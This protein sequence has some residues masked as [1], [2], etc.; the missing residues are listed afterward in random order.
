MSATADVRREELLRRRLRGEGTSGAA[1]IGRA[2]RS[3]PLALSFGQEQMWFLDQL[4]PGSTEYLVPVAFRLLGALE[5]DALGSAWDMLVR[6]HEM[7][8]TRH[9]QGEGGPHQ[10]IDEPV[11]GTLATVSL[12]EV[13]PDERERHLE[14]LLH[15]ESR[16]PI[17][18]ATQ[19]PVR[20][21]LVELGVAEHVLLVTFHHIACDAWSSRLLLSEL[22][23]LYARYR[24]KERKLL[25]PLPPLPVQYA[26]YAAWQRNQLSAA[27]RKRQLGYWRHVLSGLAPLD[28]PTDHPRPPVRGY[29]GDEVDFVLSPEVGTGVVE[30]ARQSRTTP[31]VVVMAAFQALLA[32]YTGRTDIAVGT[33]VSGRTRPELQRLIGYA[34]NTVVVRSRWT[35]DVTFRALLDHVREIVLDAFDHGDV[36]FSHVVDELQPQR[37]LSR[38]PLFQVVFTMH[39]SAGAAPDVFPDLTVEPLSADG[40]VARC[41]LELQVVPQ[42]DGSLRARFL[43]ATELFL[44]ATV[45]RMARHLKRLLAHAVAEPG[46]RVSALRLVDDDELAELTRP[47]GP[48]PRFEH[49]LT[50]FD[51]VVTATPDAVAVVT[52]ECPTTF[53]ELDTR[54]DRIAHWLSAVGVG[55]ED[56]IGILLDRGVDLLATMLACWR[57]GAA[58]LPLGPEL[59]ARRWGAMLRDSDAKLVVTDS[60]PDRMA[61]LGDV[62][63]GRMMVLD[64]ATHGAPV[65][66]PPVE[67]G[68]LTPDALAYVIYTSGSTGVPKGVAVTHR[69]L[70]NH[71]DWVLAE[72]V[73]AHSGGAPLFSTVASDVVVPVLFAPLLAGR[74]VH[75]LPQDMDLADLGARLVAGRPYAFLKLTPG[76]L[77]VL[78][79]QLGPEEIRGL[80]GTVVAGGD[81]LLNRHALRWNEWLGTGR[82]I[83]EYGPTEITV[84]N[85]TFVPS[86]ATDREVVPIGTPIPHTSMYVLDDHLRPVPVGVIGEVCVGGVGVVRGYLNRPEVTAERFVPD[87]F[88]EPGSRLYRTGDLGR[89]L[90][91]GDVEFVGRAD[92]QVKIR[93]YRVELGEI[94][95]VFASHPSV[96]EC[97]V[98]L[99]EDGERRDLVCYFVPAAGSA[100][101]ARE[102]RAW[103]SEQLPEYMVPSAVVELDRI[104]LTSNGKL[105]VAALPR[106]P[107]PEAEAAPEV[108]ADPV[109]RRLVEVWADVLGVGRVGAHDGFFELGGDSIRAVSVVGA[110]REA[111]FDVSVRDVFAHQTVA[112]LAD[113]V[114]GRG[115]V[116]AQQGVAEFALIS[117]ED[118][119]ALPEGVTDAYPLSR[120]Q[121]GMI[122]EMLA[123]EQR[124]Y[125]NVTSFRIRDAAPFSLTAMTAA[126]RELVR[127]HE[128]LRTS[129]HLSDYSVPMQLVHAT[130]ELPLGVRDVSGMDAARVEQILREHS[131]RERE[132]LFDL[133]TP[134]LMRF[135]VHLTGDD[136]YWL[137][138]TECH[139]ILEGWGHHTMMMEFLDCYDRLRRGE[140]LEAYQAPPV[141]FAD[142]VAEEMAA[143]ESPEHA[144]YWR[145][146]VDNHPAFTLP[147]QW[148]DPAVPAGRKYQTA[149]EWRDLEDG[150]RAAATAAGVS[151]KCVMVAA[152]A[153][154]LAQ[155]TDEPSFHFGLI[156][157]ARPERSGADRVYGMYLN[158]V[159]FAVDRPSGRWRDVLRAVFDRE[160]EL[161]PHRRFPY[162]EIARMRPP[163]E[164]LV[165]TIFNYQDFH[166]VDT[167]L[168]DDR[169]GNDDSPT[170]FPLSVSSRVGM[171][172]V[173]VDPRQVTEAQ[174]DLI[175]RSFRLVLEAIAEDVDSDAARAALPAE[176]RRW[177][178]E[179]ARTHVRPAAQGQPDTLTHALDAFERQVAR[180]PNAVAVRCG[181]DELSYAE[182]D[183]CANALAQRLRSTGFGPGRVAGVVV[184]RDLNLLVSLL[185]TWKA[186]GAYVPLGWELPSERWNFLLADSGAHCVV[187]PPESVDRVPHTFTGPA[188]LV[189]HRKLAE[190][191]RSATPPRR[192]VDS[193]ELAY[194]IYTSGSTGRP[195]GVRI[196]HAGLAGY[197]AWVVDDYASAR[198]GGAP[199]FSTPATD[200]TVTTL[201]GPLLTGQPV[202]I[203]PE[204]TDLSE[205]GR[206]LVDG[207]PYSFVKLTPGHL[208]ILTQQLDDTALRG[209]VGT[210]VVGG[211]LFP[212]A[213]A[214]QWR[215]R[216]GDAR[217]V[218]EYGPTEIT[219][220]NSIQ[221]VH[222]PQP[223]VVPIG[224]PLPGTSLHV[225]DDNL[226][227]VPV[228]V[229]GE[230]CV[231]GAGLAQGYSGRAALTAD[232]FVPD[233]YGEPGARLYRTG[234]VGRVRPDGTVEVLGRRDGQVKIRGYRVELGEI[235]AVLTGHPVI[236]E[237]KV[238]LRTPPEGAPQLVA[239][240]VAERDTDAI[241]ADQLGRWL[242]QALPEY[243]VPTAY[244]WL[245]RMPLS[246]NGKLDTAALP[247]PERTT[248]SAEYTEPGT[249]TEKLV[250]EIWRQVLGHARIGLDDDFFALGGDSIRAVAL[251]SALQAAGISVT[252]REVFD[253]PT[254]AAL[255]AWIA[256]R[257]DHRR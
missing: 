97:R 105:D 241:G 46:S 45:E 50:R 150:L 104:P 93:G 43:F 185:A 234:D 153:K 64:E 239:Y 17:D 206:R 98:V 210:L 160:V 164:R 159:P 37:D 12:T 48:P 76:H 227:P 119:A 203:V 194:V 214:E 28:L 126:A 196:S 62:F 100:T 82:V 202:H 83:N 207:A 144:R 75:L 235:E 39:E 103:L 54:I 86:E 236:A 55:P 124:R 162:P 171:I 29:A 223:A 58:Y 233:P 30:L 143:I 19:W 254:V 130:A 8:R 84:G 32:R 7:L 133:T 53:A 237:A 40:G 228:G 161:W 192:D 172:F 232:R 250:A 145:G 155:L 190:S 116:E 135:F 72:Y 256:D 149:V 140:E 229:V 57:V 205:L 38:T 221:E 247:A 219:V 20:A 67:A 197:L 183:E 222:G 9:R 178:L 189:D 181:D 208:E 246:S 230:V 245:D 112:A 154:V 13:G 22:G 1:G 134:G 193:A 213:T 94:E 123:D 169:A 166:Q 251:S 165:N 201:F 89:V 27:G 87:P 173:T 132:T 101:E 131:D 167:D 31:F 182:L 99:R 6:R 176:Y 81:V 90:P 115:T 95:G 158:T 117:S 69:G 71:L 199:L 34:I 248:T 204:D 68:A 3:G 15:A 121:I 70:A 10:V 238:L 157:D 179:S 125:H 92:T 174:A 120:N 16:T 88:G 217:V 191:G 91:S 180:T 118:R 127:R 257:A 42:P 65:S 188:V 122:V 41:D 249:K 177:L 49:T 168:V 243:M 113:L 225:L 36:P 61:K 52:D 60:T 35:E 24:A 240:L 242:S 4:N 66:V 175:A 136:G 5:K 141:R 109:E 128:A 253:H 108:P 226:E 200:L 18:L 77:E 2:D 209:K 137:T 111:G 102:L 142:F 198:A 139:P 110:M 152:Y 85:S 215:A 231:G 80:A 96:R 187:T 23:A 244:T 138:V 146:V 184:R 151:L 51:R 56:L 212:G 11:T 186:G 107:E 170:E 47:A 106:A 216:L 74:P 163:R 14:N 59:P 26:D 33:V 79:R 220:A 114:R 218:N 63:K 156:C 252:V 211:D 255:S 78:S 148:G 21:T 25:A 147:E 224:R 44:P 129:L 73:G 195:K